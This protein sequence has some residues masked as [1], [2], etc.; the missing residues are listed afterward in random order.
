MRERDGRPLTG[1]ST[2][3]DESHEV[4][5][6]ANHFGTLTTLMTFPSLQRLAVIILS[7]NAYSMLVH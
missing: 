2:I 4:A 6:L 7:K 1:V 3:F 5:C